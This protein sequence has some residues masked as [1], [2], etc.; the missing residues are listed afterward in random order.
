[1]TKIAFCITIEYI[2][3]ICEEIE[4]IHPA[5]PALVSWIKDEDLSKAIQEFAEIP[6]M[7]SVDDP[8]GVVEPQYFDVNFS[9]FL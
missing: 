3:I 9:R 5:Q 2:K 8:F 6:K 7:S 1:M 4:R